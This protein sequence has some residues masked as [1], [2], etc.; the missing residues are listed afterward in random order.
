M[1][2]YLSKTLKHT[3]QVKID[4]DKKNSKIKSQDRR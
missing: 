3:L 4:Q 2:R 1:N